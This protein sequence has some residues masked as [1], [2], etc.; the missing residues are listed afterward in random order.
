MMQHTGMNRRG[1]LKGL[2]ASAAGGLI[3]P[4]LLGRVATAQEFTTVSL[5]AR[6]AG[7]GTPAIELNRFDADAWICLGDEIE[8]FW[9][10]TPDVRQVD[11]GNE[12]GVFPADQGGNE[13][14]LNWGSVKVSPTTHVSYQI[15]ALDGDFD[16]ASAAGVRVYGREREEG[17]LFP[18]DEGEFL[19]QLTSNATSRTREI[20]VWETSLPATRFSPRL[21]VKAIKALREATGPF[22]WDVLKVDEGGVERRFSIA[23]TAS[24]QNPFSPANSDVTIPLAGHWSFATDASIP[25]RRVPFGVELVC[26]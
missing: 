23:A 12:L 24:F 16:A 20:D 21:N 11:L 22:V 26:G 17:P 15:F 10:A 9:V 2:G 8:L 1:F 3:V 19:A 13:N 7:S 4:S 14:G 25:D 18:I 6:L 5:Y